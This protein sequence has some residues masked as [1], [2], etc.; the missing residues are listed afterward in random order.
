MQSEATDVSTSEPHSYRS[1]DF[2]SA[3]LQKTRRS[4]L[5]LLP[6]VLGSHTC[7]SALGEKLSRERPDPDAMYSSLLSW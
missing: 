2:R 3:H 4:S 1:P 7:R 5:L 6:E